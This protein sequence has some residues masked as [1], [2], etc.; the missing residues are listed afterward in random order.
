MSSWGFRVCAACGN[1]L[2]SDNFSTN[3][4]NK[5]VGISRCSVC[6]QENIRENASGFST[7]RSNNNSN[8]ARFDYYYTEEGSFRYVYYGVYTG[9]SRTGQ[10]CVKKVFKEQCDLN[11]D[12]YSKD[13]DAVTKTLNILTQWNQ[14]GIIS[15]KI[16]LNV[17]EMWPCTDSADG[18]SLVEP[19][20]ENYEKFNS[21]S[22]WTGD[23]GGWGD[24]MQA[25]SHYSYHISSGQFTL[26][27]LQG[28]IDHLG[29]VLTDPAV[30]SQN[31]RFGVTDLGRQGMSS[32]FSEHV[33]NSYCQSSWTKPRDTH[34]YYSACCKTTMV[35]CKSSSDS[36]SNYSY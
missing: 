16:R 30:H 36:G 1:D 28:G 19:F 27:D 25:L 29:P 17:P 3:Q 24:V 26:C 35:C 31:R 34:K 22:G 23:S 14:A 21:N 18:K 15:K 11:E 32:F 7:A 8:R 4:W 20:I 6:V 12:F 33:C 5:G 2:D 10:K 9:G 13:M